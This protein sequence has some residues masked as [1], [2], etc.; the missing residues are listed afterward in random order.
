MHTT[1][2]MCKHAQLRARDTF[3]RSLGNN[4]GVHVGLCQAAFTSIS[5]WYSKLVIRHCKGGDAANSVPKYE[6]SNK[7]FYRLDYK[8]MSY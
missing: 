6:T 2:K 8:P 5:D 7:I 1:K 3:T 4:P